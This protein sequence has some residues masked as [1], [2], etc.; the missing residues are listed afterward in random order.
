MTFLLIY[1]GII[2]GLPDLISK[3][4]GINI[5][6]LII[7]LIS[8]TIIC[9][10]FSKKSIPLFKISNILSIISIISIIF[11]FYNKVFIQSVSDIENGFNQKINQID[12]SFYYYINLQET[13]ADS[14]ETSDYEYLEELKKERSILLKD[15]QIFNKKKENLGY[16]GLLSW[17]KNL[18][19]LGKS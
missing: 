12:D 2:L 6:I 15:L 8:S 19:L 3:F 13:G 16:I 4:N 5:I 10:H 7:L 17:Q 14:W 18:V 11:L 9:L 1:S